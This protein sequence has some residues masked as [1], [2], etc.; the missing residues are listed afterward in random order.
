MYQYYK[1][2][3]ACLQSFMMSNCLWPLVE[4]DTTY[5]IICT[6]LASCKQLEVLHLVGNAIDTRLLRRIV[7]T[8]WQ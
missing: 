8:N 2:K 6:G 4:A 3:Y 1:C 7:E 5:G